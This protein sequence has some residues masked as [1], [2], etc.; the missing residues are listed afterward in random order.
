MPG[1][2]LAPQEDFGLLAE[3]VGF[4]VFGEVGSQFAQHLE[5]RVDLGNFAKSLHYLLFLWIL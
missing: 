2:G 4:G 3:L 1:Q 5:L